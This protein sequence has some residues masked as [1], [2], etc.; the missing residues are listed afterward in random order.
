LNLAAGW[1]SRQRVLP[2]HFQPFGGS[3]DGFPVEDSYVRLPE[4]PG[5]GFEG[6]R[7]IV[8]RHERVAGG[9]AMFHP[10]PPVQT[11]CWSG[12]LRHLFRF[13][14]ARAAE[15]FSADEP[16]HGISPVMQQLSA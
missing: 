12:G 5:I 11:Q 2:W 15:F 16:P 8:P 10:P 7:R 1:D 3:A 14:V 4:I 9:L 13:G 6:Q